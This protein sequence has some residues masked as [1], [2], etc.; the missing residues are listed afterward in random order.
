MVCRVFALM[1]L[2]IFCHTLCNS[3]LW[4]T[5]PSQASG[6]DPSFEEQ[7]ACAPRK[8]S[9]QTTQIP[10][11]TDTN[12]ESVEQKPF[13]ILAL[14]NEI[15]GHVLEFY[16]VPDIF[17]ESAVLAASATWRKVCRRF[18]D[19]YDTFGFLQ[20]TQVTIQ[21]PEALAAFITPDPF[22]TR[23]VDFA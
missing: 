10:P 13:P 22:G 3:A 2:S 8:P 12:L 18:R 17:D 15:L 16:C 23:S 21:S 7:T 11:T 20:R 9:T 5:K 19:V 4:A 14:P 1:I 6:N